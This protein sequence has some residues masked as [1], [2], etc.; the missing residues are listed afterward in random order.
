MLD[1]VTYSY[2]LFPL[3]L[4]S[5][6]VKSK[7]KILLLLACYG[8][9]FFCFI[10]F[11]S[12]IPKDIKK[13]FQGLYTFLEYFFF[14]CF[15]WLNIKSIKFKKFIAIISIGFIIF[16][17][18]FV[19]TTTLLRVDSIPIGIETIL[20]FI[21][22]FYFLFEF[23]KNS[24]DVFIYNHYA[25]WLSFGIMIYLGGSFFLNIF[26]NHLDK[27]AKLKFANVSYTT[28]IIKNILFLISVLVYKKF[29]SNNLQ[30]QPPKKIPNLDMI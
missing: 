13:Y 30:K 5:Y 9:V 24:K 28:E 18:Y 15:I 6:I 14:T 20:V 19:T 12:S 3:L 29:P 2:L 10:H 22:I 17:I 21:Y 23:S 25:F 26:F 27:H 16:Q 1:I 11:D 4:F 8:L 7:D